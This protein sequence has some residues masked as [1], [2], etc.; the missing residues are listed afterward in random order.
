MRSTSTGWTSSAKRGITIKSQAVRLP[1]DGHVLNMI[2][3]PGARRLHSTRSR[4]PSRRGAGAILLVDEP[5]RAS[6]ADAG[7]PHIWPMNND[8]HIMPGAQQDRPARRPAGEV[9]RRARRAHRLRT[10]PT[11]F[12]S[13]ARRASGW[14]ELLDHV[15]QT[16][17]RPRGR[18]RLGGPA[19]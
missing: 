17:A 14:K 18:R 19:R 6:S 15:V 7:Q 13:R 11:C 9:R 2:D 16:R 3:T 1:W 10:P 4:A 8:L 12:A 5:P